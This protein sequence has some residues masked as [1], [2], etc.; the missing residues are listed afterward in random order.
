MWQIISLTDAKSQ[1]GITEQD[2]HVM[3]KYICWEKSVVLSS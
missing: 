3:A 2:S 1:G